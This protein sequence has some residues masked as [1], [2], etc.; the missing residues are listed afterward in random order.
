MSKRDERTGKRTLVLDLTRAEEH[1]RFI[2]LDEMGLG[3]T[4]QALAALTVSAAVPALVI[5]PNSAKWVWERMTNDF[6]PFE[7]NVVD[8]S[9]IQRTEQIHRALSGHADITIIN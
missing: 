5:C 6:T 1:E 9:A 2:L 8:G 7:P 3:K 4:V